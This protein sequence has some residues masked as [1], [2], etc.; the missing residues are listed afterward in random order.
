MSV[1]IGM[2][3]TIAF[4]LFSPPP[5]PKVYP[6]AVYSIHLHQLQ[7]AEFVAAAVET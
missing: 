7:V 2:L 3:V 4:Y 6:L 1:E 5:Y